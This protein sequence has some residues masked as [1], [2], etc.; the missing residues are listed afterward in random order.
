MRYEVDGKTTSTY[1]HDQNVLCM[2]SRGTGNYLMPGRH[3]YTHIGDR[4]EH[5]ACKPGRG[6][7]VRVV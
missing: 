4:E 7:G 1:I 5:S 2:P 6:V 3:P